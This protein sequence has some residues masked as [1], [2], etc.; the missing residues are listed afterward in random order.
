LNDRIAGFALVGWWGSRLHLAMKVLTLWVGMIL[1]LPLFGKGAVVEDY[2]V[3]VVNSDRLPST[4]PA[5]I[6]RLPGNHNFK[7][8][9]G[10]LPN[11]ELVM[12]VAHPHAEE[13][14]ASQNV[15]EGARSL[16]VH[17]VLY[18]STDEGKTWGRGR[19]V[20]ELMGGHEP[21]V[22]VIDGVLFVK[23]VV[24][25]SGWYPSPYAERDH[26]Y[27]VVARSVD[28]GRS[29][30]TTIFD[31]EVTGAGE[32]ERLDCSRNVLKLP[33]GRLWIGVA[34]GSR[35]RV[36]LSED[37]GLTWNFVDAQVDGAGYEGVSRSFF[38]EAV[39]FYTNQGQLMML[40]RVDYAHARFDEPLSGHRGYDGQAE[41]DNFDGEVLFTS[42]DAGLTWIPVQAIGFPALMYPSIVNL[43]GNWMLFTYTVREIPPEGTGAI[44]PKVGIQA[45]VVEEEADGTLIFDFSRDV[46]VIDASTPNSMRNAGGFG[47]TLRMPDGTLVTPFSYPV[48]DPEILALA[49]AKEY[50]KEE[51]YDYWASLQS[52]Y[53]AR[54][55]DYLRDDPALTELHLR[56]TFSALFL[57]GHA[58]N[59]GGIATGVVRWRLPE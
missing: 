29:F 5:T 47:N 52:T 36:A 28:G 53:S 22:S 32:D 10:R 16:A 49:D 39:A 4:L 45:I 50:L 1:A 58:A 19:H 27:V 12:F 34:V 8:H 41:S 11:G 56:R 26:S 9:A 21:S 35:H 24:H 3:P 46:I 23:M 14:H 43:E 48:I 31:R 38:N 15:P 57:Y 33:D 2:E 20:R 51:V 18:R 54:Y 25:G 6:S 37:Q 59:K 30:T 44:H 17:V 55:K 7:P 40:A 13:V 42:E